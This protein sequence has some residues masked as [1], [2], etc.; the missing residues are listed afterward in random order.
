ME[1]VLFVVAVGI[2]RG[3]FDEE[4][5]RNFLSEVEINLSDSVFLRY[6]RREAMA[7]LLSIRRV[8]K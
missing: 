2:E 5:Y 7:K 1:R 8:E 6:N 4:E 3:D